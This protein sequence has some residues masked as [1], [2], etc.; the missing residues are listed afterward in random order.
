MM[1]V[2]KWIKLIHTKQ[3]G[4]T[5]HKTNVLLESRGRAIDL[6]LF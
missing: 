2:S 3:T 1:P 4:E 5:S 6:F